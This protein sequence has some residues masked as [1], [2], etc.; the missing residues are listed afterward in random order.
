MEKNQQEMLL[1]FQM[2][3]QQI[4]Q[5]NE[6]LQAVDQ[7]IMEIKAVHFGL[8]ELKGS[9]DKEILAPIG[10]GIFVKAKIISEKLIV[11]I[12]DRNLVEKNIEAAKKLIEEQIGKLE[13]AKEALTFELQKIDRE[14]TNTIQEGQE[15]GD[16]CNHEHCGEEDHECSCEG[17][18]KHQ[19]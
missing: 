11:D 1:K 5:I 18:C 14:L 10:R 2:L 7:G 9:T 19:H 13:K 16:E 15:C 8:D 6:Q 17:G 12:G 4:N 3:E